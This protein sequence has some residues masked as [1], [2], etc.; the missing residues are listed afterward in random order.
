MG[1][2][3]LA[4]FPKCLPVQ[5][6]DIPYLAAKQSVTVLHYS[7]GV[8][9]SIRY[10]AWDENLYVPGLDGEVVVNGGAI[11]LQIVIIPPPHPP[12]LYPSSLSCL[13][14]TPLF[15]SHCPLAL[16]TSPFPLLFQSSPFF[17]SLYSS[18]T[19]RSPPSPS[20]LNSSTLSSNLIGPYLS[21]PRSPPLL[22]LRSSLATSSSP[23]SPSYFSSSRTLPLSSPNLLLPLAYP[24]AD[25]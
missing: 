8:D 5:A 20:I 23:P 18:T 3:F 12:F 6:V 7:G 13:P 24:S 10:A 11:Q 19:L 22:L 17:P 25:P 15:S 2:R 16:L 21:H 14:S 4:M 9:G 1:G